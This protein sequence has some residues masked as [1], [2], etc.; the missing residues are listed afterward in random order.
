M[1][2]VAIPSGVWV[3]VMLVALALLFDFLNGFHD[4]ANSI[5]T[6]VSTGVLRP[7][8]AVV[9]AAF[10]NFLALFVFQ[11]GVAA[12]VGKGIVLPEAV[13]AHVIFAALMAS[14][15][16]N[17][18]TWYLGIPSS[19]SHALIG[20]LIGAVLCH[21]GG[22]GLIGQGIG[23]IVLFLLLAPVL[24]LLFGRGMMITVSYLCRNRAP[25]QVG[26]L[27]RYLQLLSS[28]AYSLAHG[29]NDAQKTIG[30][31]WLLLLATGHESIH[32]V[33]PPTWVILACYAAIALGTLLGGWR[34]V[35][36]MGMRITPLTP[37]SGFCTE[38]GAA[39]TLTFV[40]ML[41]IPVSTTQTI[42][43]AI[44]GT[45]T[46]VRSS[47]VHWQVVMRIVAVWLVTLPISAL[48]A[49]ACYHL[50]AGLLA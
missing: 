6:I 34:I 28:S 26:P 36:T 2:S 37:V 15:L 16:W 48:I 45:G 24:G 46:V 31:I 18:I 7:A 11:L 32:A 10:F 25:A 3:I 23:M 42:A 44:I 4:A 49:A 38:T 29:G 9:M 21:S 40:N 27:F 43:G 8:Q 1:E 22:Q 14:I 50:S 13:N 39:C 35:R 47:A 30:I 33:T 12:T 19:S 20:G 5:A 41:G 17:L